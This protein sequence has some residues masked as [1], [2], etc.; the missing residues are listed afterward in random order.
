MCINDSLTSF[1]VWMTVICDSYISGREAWASG[2]LEEFGK[3]ISASGLSSIENYEC[4]TLFFL[5]SSL[6]NATYPKVNTDHKSAFTDMIQSISLLDSSFWFTLYEFCWRCGATDSAI[7]DSP[8]GSWCIWC[9]FQWC[10]L[11]GML[12][13]LCRCRK[14]WGSCFI[15]EGW[16]WK[17]P[18]RVC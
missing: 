8:E 2:N 12:S 11:Q 13:C 4:G 15:C 9:P 3:L 10:R 6:Q 14:S 17:G 16:I 1:I 7:Q 18:T 5:P